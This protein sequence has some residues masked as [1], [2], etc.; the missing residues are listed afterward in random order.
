MVTPGYFEAMRLPRI[1]GRYVS[2]ADNVTAPGVVVINE[3][4]AREYWPGEDPI[5]K[6]IY[7]EED[8]NQPDWLTI[9]GAAANAKQE[10]WASDP[11]PEVYLSAL[12]SHDFLGDG[13]STVSPHMTYITLVI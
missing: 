7:L 10:D 4:A 5:G 3:R 13:R 9:I 1:R 8:D 2:E 11:Y 12:Q 6:R